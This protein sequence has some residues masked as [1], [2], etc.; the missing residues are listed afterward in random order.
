MAPTNGRTITKASCFERQPADGG[1]NGN[2]AVDDEGNLIRQMIAFLAHARTPRRVGSQEVGS[3]RARRAT[4]ST[5]LEAGATWP[6]RALK[7]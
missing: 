3:S 2:R 4:S 6:S 7:T 5:G 1:Q